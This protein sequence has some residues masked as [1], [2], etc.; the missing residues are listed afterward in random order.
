MSP[1]PDSFRQ[2]LIEQINDTLSRSGHTSPY[3]V[4][5]DPL[6]VWK[7]L[8]AVV[9]EDT[10]IELWA[11]EISELQLRERFHSESHEDKRR[12]IWLPRAR[13]DITYFKVFEIRAA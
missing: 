13:S 4:W 11:E 2:W 7:D 9:E 5:C 6:R 3:I 1:A 12:I 8:L 10:G